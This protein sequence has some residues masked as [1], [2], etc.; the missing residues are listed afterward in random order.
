[1][2][3]ARGSGLLTGAAYSKPEREQERG[4]LLRL[5]GFDQLCMLVGADGVLAFDL[6]IGERK[7]FACVPVLQTPW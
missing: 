4:C 6:A 1:M 7:S 2:A 5:D 3:E